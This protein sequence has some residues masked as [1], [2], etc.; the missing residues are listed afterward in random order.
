MIITVPHQIVSSINS[1]T[2]FNGSAFTSIIVKSQIVNFISQ[3]LGSFFTE[4]KELSIEKSSLEEIRKEDLAQF[5]KLEMLWLHNNDLRFLPGDLFEA[6][7]EIVLINFENNKITRMGDEL[8]EPLKNLREAVFQNNPCSNEYI[9]SHD[10][11]AALAASLK[12]N[13]PS[14]TA[15]IAAMRFST[16]ISVLLLAYFQSTFVQVST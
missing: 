14:S 6:N 16:W 2:N 11:V 13:C 12:K 9:V 5:P 3:G 1:Q 15:S 7:L 10:E 4:L 8:L